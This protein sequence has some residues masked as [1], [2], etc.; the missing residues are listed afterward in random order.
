M[1]CGVLE[2]PVCDDVIGRIVEWERAS[3]VADITNIT[4]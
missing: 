4:S 2:G 1:N 3:T